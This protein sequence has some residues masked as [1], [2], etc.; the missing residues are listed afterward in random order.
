M[1]AAI[2]EMGIEFPALLT[3]LIYER[4]MFMVK[5]LRSLPPK[6]GSL[7]SCYSQAYNLLFY[8]QQQCLL[9]SFPVLS[10]IWRLLLLIAVFDL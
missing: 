5:Q 7:E 2:K 6:Y 4:D 1:T 8:L 9:C 10:G 3:P